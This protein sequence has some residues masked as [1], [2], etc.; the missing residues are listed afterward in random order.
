MGSDKIRYNK[1]KSGKLFSKGGPR[2]IQL[3]QRIKQEELIRGLGPAPHIIM[4]DR[5]APSPS[6]VDMSQYLPLNKVKTKIEAAVEHTKELMQSKYESGVKNLNDQLEEVKGE[7][8]ILQEEILNKNADLAKLG[9]RISSTPDISDKARGKKKKKDLRIVELESEIKIK[10]EHLEQA[11][12]DVVDMT[13]K[14]ENAAKLVQEKDVEVKEVRADMTK[15]D[16]YLHEKD[17]DIHNR[18]AELRKKE[19]ELRERDVELTKLKSKSD[20]ADMS[21]EL[22][23]KLDRLYTKIADGSIRHLV[24]S[25]MGRPALEDKIFIDPLESTAGK[26]LDPHIDI[27]EEKSVEKKDRDVSA[28]ANKLRSLL[29]SSK[30]RI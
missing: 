26:N 7:V 14:V 25:N 19:V 6:T 24:G 23:D 15:R 29:K 18:N 10:K 4:H 17:I 27:K 16:A 5:S 3:R 21:K 1:E 28:D 9:E 12:R 20:S 13:T 11:N 22:S 2:D 30:G 8:S